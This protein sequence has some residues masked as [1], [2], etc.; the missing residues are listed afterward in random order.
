MLADMVAVQST[1]EML[2]L[3]GRLLGQS[4]GGLQVLGVNSLKSVAPTPGDLV[5]QAI[6][7]VGVAGRV[8][9]LQTSDLAVAI[10][11]QRVGRLTWHMSGERLRIGQASLPTARLIL[12][13]GG[14]LDFTEPAKTKRIS[15]TISNR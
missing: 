4:V 10:D 2:E 15:V 6:T 7:A 5:G 9:T 13:D 3:L 1:D 12:A 11:L 8:I 14:G